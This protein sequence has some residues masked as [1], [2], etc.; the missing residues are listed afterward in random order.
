MRQV[1]G[2]EVASK[3]GAVWG[4]DEEGQIEGVWRH[5]GHDGLW[6]GIGNLLQSRI[7]SLHLAM[8]EFLL[9][10]LS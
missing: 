7:H 6:F 4:L 3:V 2:D 8:R 5:C 10:S 9:Y 1:C